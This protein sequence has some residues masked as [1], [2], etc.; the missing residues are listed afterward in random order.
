MSGDDVR[1]MQTILQREGYFHGTPL[2]NFRMVTRDA[3]KH[4]QNTHIGR[5]GAFLEADGV[6]GPQTWWALHNPH[7]SAQR[8]GLERPE[9]EEPEFGYR[10]EFVEWMY[11]THAR[12][13]HEIPD[14]SNYGDGVTGIVNSC[15]FSYGIP[16]CL[17]LVSCGWRACFDEPP[18]GAMHVHV[19]TFWNEARKAGKAFG[20]G[21]YTPSPGDIGIYNYR[22]GLR[23]DGTL[24]GPGHATTVVRVSED[25]TVHNAIE[26]NAG[27]RCKHS[28]RREADPAFV[29]YV[30]LFGGEDNPLDFPRGVTTAPVTELS[31]IE[32]R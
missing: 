26:G 30:N 16:W 6:V 8:N 4:F 22:Q 10:G 13:V 5:D 21:R 17:A 31:L 3:V 18:L 14:G 25:G 12:D 32:S 15:G 19:S 2:G 29:G 20:K 11:D 28:I 27:N 24:A 9:K 7:G 1:A 23:Q